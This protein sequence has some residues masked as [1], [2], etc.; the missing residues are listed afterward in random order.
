MIIMTLRFTVPP[1][2]IAD[3][4]A[5]SNSIKEPIC[6]EPGCNHFSLYND[7]NNDNALMLVGEWESQE[8]LGH[9]GCWLS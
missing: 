4:I 7:I 5:I 1:E 3:V 6:V 2:K 9:G 8:A